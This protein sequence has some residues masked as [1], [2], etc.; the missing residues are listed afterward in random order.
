MTRESGVQADIEGV[1]AAHAA[2]RSPGVFPRDRK[3]RVRITLI[4]LLLGVG[5]LWPLPLGGALLMVA[6]TFVLVISLEEELDARPPATLIPVPNP[7]APLPLE[8]TQ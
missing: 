1:T 4:A 3:R 5:L 6:A 7:L 2:P 8:G